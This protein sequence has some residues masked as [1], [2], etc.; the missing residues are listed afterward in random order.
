MFMNRTDCGALPLL[1]AILA[2]APAL[3]DPVPAATPG[4]LAYPP[5]RAGDVVDDYFGRKIA[6]PYRWLEDLESKDT[7]AWVA[8]QNKVTFAYLESLPQREAIRKRLTELW[9]YQRT[10]LPVQA[11]GQIWFQQNSGLQRQAPL[12]R[13]ADPKAPPQLVLDPNTLSPDGSVQMAQWA[14]SPDG[15][16]LAYT[17]APGGSDVQD[18]RVRDLADGKDLPSVV[19]NVKF[20][21]LEWTKDGKGFFYSRYRGTEATASFADAMDVHQV[22]YHW[23]DGR[24]PDRLVFERVDFPKDFTGAQ[25][26]DDGRWLYLSSASGSLGNRLWIADLGSPTWPDLAAKPVVV[27]AEEDAFHTPLGVVGRTLYLHTTYGAPRGRIV[28]AAIGDPDRSKWRTV[29][30][31]GKDAIVEGGVELVG[32]HFAVVYLADVQSRVRLF[33]L[34]GSP[35]GEIPLPEPGSV[36][37]TASS[38]SGLSA[39]NDG[40]DLFLNFVSFLRPATIY[41]YDLGKRSL[42]PFHP[43]KSPFDASK[44]ETRALFY[45]SKDGT[46]VPM[47]VTLKKGAKLDGSHPT[48]LFGYGGF[49][50]PVVPNFSPAVAGWLEM[51]GV[52]AIANL[53]GG[54]EYGSE[55]HK[56]GTRERKQNVFDDFIAAAEFLVREK[57]TTPSRLAIRGGSNGGLLVAAT[58]IQ[59]PDLFAVALPAVGVLDMLRY[60][61]FSA[62]PFWSADYGSAD[63]PK[64]V[65]YLLAYSP[66][67]N[68]KPGTCYPATLITTAD[69]DDRVVPSHS[70]KFAAALQKAQGCPRP[71][72][73][74]VEVA[75]SH[76]YRPTDRVIAEFADLWAFT[77]ANMTPAQ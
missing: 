62:G 8:A 68:L 30:P 10:A 2:A 51:G 33:G 48:V 19:R 24:T 56:A 34:D 37:G 59:R 67:H 46:R 29:V 50:I 38:A 72:L 75:G 18:V 64:A 77:L 43:P 73:I 4:A 44:F 5:T 3:A 23:V 54:G 69:R 41:R 60:H 42:E 25:V 16:Y 6:D 11:A 21:G 22:W 66:L 36:T 53:R 27:A 49:N 1:L 76:G 63:D 28:A 45:T 9:D 71:T 47:F 65:D 57:Y 12:Y 55:W 35:K 7:A 14:P 52:Y 39:N 74:R 58:M 15:R 70:F 26:S 13:Q 17:L 32:G 40:S 20:T 31:E 61:K